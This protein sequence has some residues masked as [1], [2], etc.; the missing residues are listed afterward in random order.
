MFLFIYFFL[1]RNAN[2]LSMEIGI[3]MSICEKPQYKN[4]LMNKRTDKVTT[5]HDNKTFPV[6]ENSSVNS[7]FCSSVIA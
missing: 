3:L 5:A 2:F 7:S 6:A 4:V 1:S